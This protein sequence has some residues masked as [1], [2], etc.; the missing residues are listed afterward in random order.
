M[1]Q[2]YGYDRAETILRQRV[3]ELDETPAFQSLRIPE[4]RSE[5]EIKMGQL[6]ARFIS[7]MVWWDMDRMR[8]EGLTA[9]D[10]LTAERAD[11]I[12]CQSCL[13]AKIGR[14][15]PDLVSGPVDLRRQQWI[16]IAAEYR[17]APDE[18]QFNSPDPSSAPV[19]QPLGFGLWTSTANVAKTSMWRAYLE[20]SRHM[21]GYPDPWH[22]WQLVVQKNGRVA[23]I[24]NATRWVE[25]VSA[26]P[27]SAGRH[28][29]PDWVKIA[30]KWD[31]VHVTLAAIVATQGFSFE[32]EAGLIP[33]AFFDVESTVWL[34]WRFAGARLV[35]T[36]MH[37]PSQPCDSQAKRRGHMRE[38]GRRGAGARL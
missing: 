4:V 20:P 13:I 12:V 3:R 22:T 25:L 11:D 38:Q 14:F 27:R 24:T 9:V 21:G 18:R 26:Y 31:G 37:R 5:H 8:G 19:V 28:I 15:A 23:E 33:P 36:A 16:K 6:L 2:L 32:T 17:D 7:V 1:S 34:K 30:K 35:D 29:F 10:A